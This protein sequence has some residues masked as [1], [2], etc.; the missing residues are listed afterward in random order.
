LSEQPP[1]NTFFTDEN[2]SGTAI[3]LARVFG[4]EIITTEEV[5]L[6]RA[7]DLTLFDYAV[8]HGYVMVTVNVKHFDPLWYQFAATGRDHPGLVYIRRKHFHS[9]RLIAEWLAL[10]A[11]EP[12]TNRIWWIP[13]AR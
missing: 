5:G 4:A 11:D 12:M 6:R 8:E 3:S 13:P 9:H 2:V 10:L 7:D 1:R